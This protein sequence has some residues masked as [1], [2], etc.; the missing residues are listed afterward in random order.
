MAVLFYAVSAA[1]APWTLRGPGDVGFAALGLT[2]FLLLLLSFGS[3][4]R[5]RKRADEALLARR[6]MERV[7]ADRTADL[8]RVNE[9][10]RAENANR[11][12]AQERLA[13][14]RSLLK[15]TIE[16]TADGILVVRRD[17]RIRLFNSRLVEMWRIPKEL[18]SLDTP[19]RA[20][21]FV[22]D[23]LLDPEP[24]RHVLRAFGENGPP[25]AG[26]GTLELRDGRFLN[27]TCRIQRVHGEA[28]GC[29][30]SF[31]D[32]SSERRAE[33]TLQ[34]SEEWH[35]ILFEA[36]PQPM[37]VFDE[38]S[39]RFLAVNE[40]A[41]RSYGYSRE[42][43]LAM[44]IK[45]IRPE[46]DIPN[47]L[48]ELSWEQNG[49]RHS[50]IWKHRKKDGTVIEVEI[51]SHPLDFSHRP[52]QM[53]LAADVT[54]RRLAERRIQERTTYLNALVEHSPIA[55]L[56]LAP[57]H[58]VQ[59][60]NPAFGRLFGYTA[61]EVL[62][63]NP[64]DVIAPEEFRTEASSFTEDV[65]SGKTIHAET[66]RRRKDGKLVEVD[67][68]GV[69]LMQ[70]GQLIGVYALYQDVTERQ[71]LSEQL[72]QAQK[73]E[74]IGRLAGG[75][76]HDFNNLL[77]VILGSTDLLL[78]RTGDRHPMRAE[79]GEIRAA[80]ERAANLTRQLLAFSRK[81]VLRPEV[82]D[83]ND[84]LTNIER[85]LSRLLGEDV[86]MTTALAEGLW[87]VRADPGQIE[88]AVVN[89]AVNA[90]DA[91]PEGGAL[92]LETK[93]VFVDPVFAGEHKGMRP[94]EY[95]L[96]VV[97]D[98]GIGMDDAVRSRLFEPFFTTKPKGK[99]TGLG[100]STTYGI[101]KQ[102]GGYIWADSAPGK[103]ASFSI[104]LPRAQAEPDRASEKPAVESV[105]GTEAILLVEDEPEVRS[106][107]ER[108]L[109]DQ[110]Y[111]VLVAD[112]PS[113]ALTIS[114]RSDLCLDL[115]VTDI[116]MPEMNGWELARRL[117]PHRPDL[118]VLYLSGYADE[119]ITRQGVLDP[120]VTLL[121]K[122]FRPRDLAQRVREV[123][124]NGSARRAG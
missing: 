124:N 86:Q 41:C 112:R 58:R 109:R 100:L 59:I 24:L 83:L 38:G 7:V 73:I 46:E 55:I 117:K 49:L 116:V 106:L 74:A 87:R 21:Q 88:Q 28:V 79:L 23:Q 65:L 107:V 35:R 110:G 9:A 47:L 6:E 78:D 62:G 2:L 115:M 82:L 96:I 13:R 90:R 94:G 19:D 76:A 54:Q 123:L 43:F 119:S 77:T 39:L 70:G 26:E 72:R 11:K 29:V 81:Q 48:E 75:I 85:M 17:G 60:M 56:V 33:R 121:E 64:D 12:K 114:L 8:A 20:L 15:A 25:P 14:S 105:R 113:E 37:W 101:V 32:I 111:Q 16:S 63:R 53:V 122:P 91:M 67:L 40:A 89:L 50:G 36:S 30:W 93:N 98:T 99:G 103:G 61:E 118:R 42:E 1:G 57:D 18:L 92:R 52:A 31:R 51:V 71:E 44:T 95:A 104:Y 108:V 120:G 27:Y 45:D 4:I 102:S 68:Y 80:G 34:E 97:T 22:A 84:L 69:P 5:T 3:R 66:K 10:L